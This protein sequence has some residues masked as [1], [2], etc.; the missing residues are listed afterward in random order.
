MNQNHIKNLV[1][2]TLE[3][4]ATDNSVTIFYT[5]PALKN[6]SYSSVKVY[7][8]IGEAP[9]CDE[10][11]D[12][13]E[14]VDPTINEISLENL[15]FETE[16]FFCIQSISNNGLKLSS[17]VENITT[18]NPIPEDLR[19]YVKVINDITGYTYEDLG[20]FTMYDY[21]IPVDGTNPN[22]DS[23]CRNYR[24]K[25]RRRTSATHCRRRYSYRIPAAGAG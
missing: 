7:A 6:D 4:V 1:D 23:H 19:P 20:C 25:S 22:F 18:G 5:I 11:D 21:N 2:I 12:I 8:K 9:K 16:Y 17:N 10:T 13:V 15:D 24:G 3:P 14:D